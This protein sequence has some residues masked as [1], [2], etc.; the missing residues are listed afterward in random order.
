MK[1]VITKERM[2]WFRIVAIALAIVLVAI[3][4]PLSSLATDSVPTIGSAVNM[5][6]KAKI[7]KSGVDV[8]TE[9]AANK[10]LTFSNNQEGYINNL[11]F[12]S[13]SYTYSAKVRINDVSYSGYASIRLILGTGK[14]SD[15]KL[16]NMELCVRPTGSQTVFFLRDGSDETVATNGVKGLQGLTVQQEY[17]YTITYD[18]GKVTFWVDDGTQ[19]IKIFDKIDVTDKLSDITLAPGFCAKGCTGAD[20]GGT[21]SDI[22]IWGNDISVLAPPEITS[23]DT[24]IITNVTVM[25]IFSNK[26][27]KL[28]NG[29]VTSNQNKTGRI[30]FDGVVLNGDYTF[31]ANAQFEDNKNLQPWDNQE[32][33][34]ERLIFRVASVEKD[35][36]QS[37]IEI[38]V[39]SGAIYIFDYVGSGNESIIRTQNLSNAYGEAKEYVLDYR[40]DGT[41]DFWQ[42]GS[43]VLSN[44]DLAE[45]GYTNIKPALGLGSEVCSFTFNN[46][47]LVS[48]TA[49][50]TASVPAMP[51]GNGD[52][53]EYM[54]V[55]SDSVVT[56]ENGTIY[57]V[58]DQKSG[59]TVFEYLP[60]DGDDTYVYGFNVRTEK[61]DQTWQGPR[62]IIGLDEEGRT[63]YLY[64][65]QS[66]LIVMARENSGKESKI[67]S[68]TFPREFNVEY[69]IDMLLEP[70]ALTLWVNDILLIDHIAMPKRAEAK[71]GITFEKTLA[72]MSNIDLYYTI[73]VEFVKP[74][75]PEK[76]VLK[77]LGDNQF[78]AADWMIV[79]LNNSKYG[80][81][82]NNTLK[83]PVTVNEQSIASPQYL[84]DNIPVSD[85]MSYYYSATYK[86][87][88]R[89]QTWQGPRFI[90]RYAGDKP[91]YVYVMSEGIGIFVDTELV[92][93]GTQKT[94]IGKSYD[95][96]F[97]TT[98]THITVWVDGVLIIENADLSDYCKDGVLKAKMGLKFE[99]CTA[100]VTN[101]AIYGDR[102]VFNE[103][104]IDP[105]LYYSKEFNMVGIPEMPEGSI[106]LFQNI[107]MLGGETDSLGV[108]FNKEENVLTTQYDVG[109]ESIEF[110]DANGSA[111]LNGLKNGSGYVFSFTHKVTSWN[112]E[113][114]EGET[115]A[116]PGSS[117]FWV[118]VNSTTHPSNSG[119]NETSVGLSGNDLMLTVKA[120][121]ATIV[122]IKTHIDR[123]NNKEYDVAIVHGKN[124]I[125]V[126]LDDE[127]KIVA[128]D[129]PAYNVKFD[130]YMANIQAEFSNFKLYEFENSGLTILPTVETQEVVSAGNTIYDAK[131]YSML[132][133]Y[134]LPIILIIVSAVIVV[135]SAAGIAAVILTYLKRRK[136]GFGTGGEKACENE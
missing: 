100:E 93:Q 128:T 130:Y 33:A 84:Y 61:A 41:F 22:K 47:H 48:K 108:T 42:N 78:N 8:T 21:I 95:I 3:Y 45:M 115:E 76:P 83:A 133:R 4:L 34:W 91:V 105:E 112:E 28:T 99:K 59:T 102:I 120:A 60:F 118:T 6:D 122:D 51:A 117:G 104:Y 106:N 127:L 110:V 18:N 64:M 58:T 26:M 15:G 70:Q 101:L 30:D 63:L 24:D 36:V 113:I 44:I 134:K 87:T 27:Y 124:W 2:K 13:N 132:A 121:G 25:D 82:F 88:V 55:P 119:A 31:Y 98:P 10:T 12:G 123:E 35:G 109:T 135:A 46:M 80:A 11:I 53:A 111:N 50:L 97:Y 96:T 71:T 14:S 79:N 125:K 103:D 73:P 89:E 38:R 23:K 16:R 57:S 29:T 32:Y 66:E 5:V 65:T 85:D 17:T 62:P 68:T 75:V 77:T 74:E 56:S 129:L 52:Y 40:E 81:Y 86:V 114:A 131:E 54:W 72:T 90:V 136:Q 69:R 116:D 94:E 9:Y 92:V 43:R 37:T 67:Y 20:G 126:Y 39:A 19:G 107:S 49:T 1:Q 7:T